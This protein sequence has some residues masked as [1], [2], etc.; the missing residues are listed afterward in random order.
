[1]NQRSRIQYPY[2]ITV[3]VFLCLCLV[4]TACKAEGNV[5]I[6][7]WNE[8][9]LPPDISELELTA[10]KLEIWWDDG[11]GVPHDRYAL[12]H[13]KQQYSATTFDVQEFTFSY[14]DTS[15]KALFNMLRTKSSPDLMVFDSRLL[16]LL[17]DIGYLDSI[18]VSTGYYEMDASVIEQI[19]SVAPDGELYAMPYGYS[20]AALLFNKEIFDE[21]EVEYPRDGMTWEEVLELGRRVFN[22]SKWSGLLVNDYDLITSQLSL[23]LIHRDTR[24][25]DFES[26]AWERLESF[27][28]ELKLLESEDKRGKLGRITAFA[29]GRAAMLA[30]P[31]F[32]NARVESTTGLYTRVMQQDGI[33]DVRWDVVGI[34][35]FDDGLS[36]A[37]ARPMLMIGIPRAGL[38]KNDAL[39]A[40]Q[41][42]LSTHVQTENT[43][44][45]LISPR[46]DVE[47]EEFAKE[48]DF[49]SGK[50]KHAFIRSE[51]SGK[52]DLS[53]DNIPLLDLLIELKTIEGAKEEIKTEVPQYMDLRNRLIEEVKGKYGW[54]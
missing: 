47:L 49:L 5:P 44:Q 45:G 39:I 9:D 33:S 32:D 27:V 2:R 14:I 16:P 19:R 10:E 31:L 8:L 3:S 25:V 29:N 53:L 36:L 48:L 11:F 1:M 50:N 42:L 22:P 20:P 51:Q 7:Q 4:L 17:I 52:F 30:V 12:E 43:R 23:Q 24:Q 34:P 21:M 13:L 37:P 6:N 46:V 41:Y 18:N 15:Q 26:D 38:N 54:E 28:T 35:V 40:M